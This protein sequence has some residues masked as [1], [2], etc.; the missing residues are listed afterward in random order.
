V[1]NA[2]V[3]PPSKT[4]ELSAPNELEVN[5]PEKSAVTPIK[6]SLSVV[7]PATESVLSIAAAP[8]TNKLPAT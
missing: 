3:V 6:E 7:T 8:E 4:I 2:P 5:M 1:F